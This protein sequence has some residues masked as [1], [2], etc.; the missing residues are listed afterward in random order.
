M[1]EIIGKALAT[2]VRRHCIQRD[3]NLELPD[4]DTNHNF[5]SVL[6]ELLDTRGQLVSMKTYI[7][8][9][10]PRKSLELCGKSMLIALAKPRMDSFKAEKAM[11]TKRDV[12]DAAMMIVKANVAV[13]NVSVAIDLASNKFLSFSAVKK[14]RSVYNLAPSFCITL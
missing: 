13:S 2:T 11:Q 4:L 3:W 8:N 10:Q 7:V 5:Q 6:R 12:F 14:K 9:D 1:E